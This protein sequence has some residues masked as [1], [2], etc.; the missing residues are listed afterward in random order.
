[1]EGYLKNHDRE[2]FTAA[3]GVALG[4]GLYRLDNAQRKNTIAFPWAPNSNINLGNT[5]LENDLRV[6]FESD[7]KNMT[8]KLSNDPK[9]K[10]VPEENI[11][12]NPN[13]NIFN[14]IKD[15]F[16]HTE[17]SRLSSPAFELKGMPKNRWISLKKNPQ[18]NV[19]E[20][21]ERNGFDTYSD[22]L[23]NYKDCP[24]QLK[25]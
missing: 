8:R 5:F 24:V 18:E 4:P 12:Q 2:L 11:A 22:L 7:L 6:D 25:K 23:D 14:G 17:S 16:F 21:F 9:K 15:G 13:T 3:E 10:Y 1:M 19:I 20:P